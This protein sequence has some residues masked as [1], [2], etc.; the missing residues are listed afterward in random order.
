M[1]SELT[2]KSSSYFILR[3]LILW[4]GST[5]AE[6]SCLVAKESVF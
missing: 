4:L 2:P 5:R 1:R 6:K 3:I